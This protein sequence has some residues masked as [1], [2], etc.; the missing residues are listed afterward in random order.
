MSNICV[1]ETK[2]HRSNK[3][4]VFRRLSGKV[5]SHKTN[6]IDSTLPTFFLSFSWSNHIEHFSFSHRLDFFDR[7]WPLSS[8]FFSL[9]FDHVSEYFGVPLL[10][11]VHE[12]SRHCSFLDVLYSAFGVLL[13][14]FFDGLF[15]LNFLFEPFFVEQF[16][17]DTFQCLC[18]FGDDFRFSGF[19]LSSLFFGVHSLTESFLVEIHEVVLRHC[20]LTMLC[21]NLYNYNFSEELN[22]NSPKHHHLV[23]T[24]AIMII[25]K[26]TEATKIIIH[27]HFFDVSMCF[28]PSTNFFSAFYI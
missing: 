17:F 1:F 28:F 20:A 11:S 15:H 4:F 7:Y 14:M 24:T 21:W 3:S 8:L 10:L 22:I 2:T 5:F 18:L 26:I 12:I 6:F 13:F 9:L 25:T 27:M 19:F 16:S 23:A